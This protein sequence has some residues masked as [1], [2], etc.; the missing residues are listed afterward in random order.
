ML[1]AAYRNVCRHS[2]THKALLKS[3]TVSKCARHFSI[4]PKL[5]P[6]IREFVSCLAQ[7][8][9]SFR[10]SSK[11]V[12]VLAQ[13]SEFYTNLLNIIRRARRRIFLSS[14][15]IGFSETELI[16]TLDDAL[17]RNP[18]LHLYLNLDYN[19]ST[20]PGPSSPILSLLPLLRNHEHRVHI[21][22]FRSPKLSATMGKIVPP[23]FNEGWGTW[24]AKIYGS[25][26]EVMISGANLNKAYFSNRQDRYL[27]FSAQPALA[28]YCFSFL[29]TVSGFSYRV[30]AAS[31]GHGPV[32]HWE[33]TSVSPCR[34]QAKAERVLSQFQMKHLLSS[35]SSTS[36]EHANSDVVI[37]PV[38]QA[39][40]FNIRE[41][42]L[43]LSMLFDHLSSRERIGKQPVMDLTSGYFGLSRE[44]QDLILK[45]DIGCSIIAASP[46]ANGF[47]GSGG[48]SGLIPEGYTLLEQ[49]FMSA[50]RA[51]SR[52]SPSNVP[53]GRNISLGEWERDGW[54]Y[55]AK[56]IWLSPSVDS[57]PVLTLFGSTNL[58]SRS[59]NLD[60]EL[61]FVMATSS[62]DLRQKL[63]E[64]VQGLNRWAV[65]WRG[66][67]RKVRW[68]TKA[69]VGLVG[70]ML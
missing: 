45:S 16:D 48:L 20:R 5:D 6:T 65:P 17:R 56:G 54:T 38:I 12:H 68:R 13:P 22:L 40:Q 34:I 24:H 15:Y 1:A 67:E 59:A 46:K 23:R 4:T 57:P 64:E 33:D 63:H 53:D 29:Q 27:H 60:T 3:F 19:R 51:A 7:K 2:N 42:E 10:V 37:F 39:G 55:H 36:E 47:Y 69:I 52:S 41:E 43:A 61:S 50:V 11:D 25:D 9:P 8:Q 44:Y 26:D 32:L 49:R 21:S 14:L 62:D 66:G 58:N 30:L 18:G 35:P 28:D 31:D 70:G